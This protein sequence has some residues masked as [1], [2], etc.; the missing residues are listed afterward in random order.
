MAELLTTEE[1]ATRLRVSVATVNRYAREGI[2]P[3][4]QI[5]PKGQRRYRTEDVDNLLLP[6]AG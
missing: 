6:K 4:V 1:V 2:L 5:R 3:S